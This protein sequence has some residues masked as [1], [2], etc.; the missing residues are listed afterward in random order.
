TLQSMPQYR[1]K[2]TLLVTCDHGRGDKI[3]S[4]WQHHGSKIEDSHEIWLAAMGPDTPP[5]GEAAS[6]TQLHQEQLAATIA[7][8]LGFNFVSNHPVATPI[9]TLYKK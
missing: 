3:K 9:T 8:L 6:H 7:Q 5:T 1:G 2:T 4:N